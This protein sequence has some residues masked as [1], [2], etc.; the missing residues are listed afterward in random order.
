MHAMPFGW[1]FRPVSM[2][3]RDGE[4]CAVVCMFV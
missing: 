3:D 1:W 4:H 2:H